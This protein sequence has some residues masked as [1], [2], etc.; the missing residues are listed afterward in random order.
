MDPLT[1]FWCLVFAIIGL[2]ITRKYIKDKYTFKFHTEM[3]E[4][5][6]RLR[7]RFDSDMKAKISEMEKQKEEFEQKTD[8][9][10][11]AKLQS[12]MDKIEE[13]KKE[14]QKEYESAMSDV[15][16]MLSDKRQNSPWMAQQYA[17]FIYIHDKRIAEY[18]EFKPHPALT[19]A[20]RVSEIAKEKRG[21]QKEL[22]MLQYQL[23]Y[24]ETVFPWLEEFK[25][26]DADEGARYVAETESDDEMQSLQRWLSPEEFQELPRQEKYQMALDRYLNN[27]NKTN[28]QTGIEYERYIGY[29]YESAG[30]TVDYIGAKRGLDDMGRD[31]I[32]EHNDTTLIVQCKRWS[33]EKTIHEKHIFQLYGTMVEYKL[34][35]PDK[36]IKAAFITT[37]K[38]SELA[39]R[40]AEYLNI[41][42][43]YISFKSYPVIKCHVSNAYDEDWG[44]RK[45][46][47]YHL[48]FDQQYDKIKNKQDGSLTY[49]YTIKEA[50]ELGFRRAWRWK[51]S[52]E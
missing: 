25:E 34:N 6:W 4:L 17:D 21:L 46:K 24:Y 30:D 19:S 40:C 49:A 9:E 23:N 2:L 36:K 41:D 38:L 37:T 10:Y 33:S 45:E 51:G 14:N 52:G 20:Q 16:S 13:L 28:W 15:D 11:K 47:I 50:E 12:E 18:L 29:L 3:Q 48:P 1:F 43:R 39:T 32:V 44:Y 7:D 26:L 5:E 42:V 31:L 8:A 22:K 35:H 27:H